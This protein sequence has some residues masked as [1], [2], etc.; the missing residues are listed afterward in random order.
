MKT[1]LQ[2]FDELGLLGAISDE[3]KDCKCCPDHKCCL[4]RKNYMS[5][6]APKP[7]V[8]APG[9]PAGGKGK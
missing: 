2:M 3:M 4:F 5:K 7:P 9:K 1:T 6:P 8:S